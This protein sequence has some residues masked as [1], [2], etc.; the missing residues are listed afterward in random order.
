MAWNSS[1]LRFYVNKLFSNYECERAQHSPAARDT[2]RAR[3]LRRAPN[4]WDCRLAA[5]VFRPFAWLEF[6]SAKTALPHPTTRTPQ[7]H[8]AH[9]WAAQFKGESK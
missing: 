4:G 5:R 9:R 2:L 3:C 8:N 1:M 7:G 6:G